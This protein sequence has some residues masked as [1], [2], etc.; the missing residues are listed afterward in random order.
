[1]FEDDLF[2]NFKLNKTDEVDVWP[3][4]SAAL[5]RRAS[6]WEMFVP[7]LSAA[8]AIAVAWIVTTPIQKTEWP[9][10]DKIQ[11]PANVSRLP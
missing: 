1:M 3:R 4:V 10:I 7:S 11:P 9:I 2:E 8:I 6:I 5:P